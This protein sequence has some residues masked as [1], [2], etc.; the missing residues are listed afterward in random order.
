MG[1]LNF[2][3]PS[4][5]KEENKSYGLALVNEF[6]LSN[7]LPEPKISF[8]PVEFS[9][10]YFDKAKKEIV[11][12]ISKSKSPVKTPGFSWSFT[13][14]KADLTPAGILCHELGH[15]VDHSRGWASRNMPKF[16]G[17]EKAVSGYEPNCLEIFAESFRLFMTNPR[18]LKI[19]RP[20]RYEFITNLGVKPIIEADWREV[21]CNA[22]PDFISAAENF[23]KNK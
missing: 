7:S 8:S 20:R 9:R 12:D 19:A 21:L 15:Y 5:P 2:P 14:Y 4:Q 18:L 3:Y 6:C 1:N 16:I 17:R 23:I 10:G 11:L 13:G 22:H